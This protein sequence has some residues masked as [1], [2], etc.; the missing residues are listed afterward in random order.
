M[1]VLNLRDTESREQA[2]ALRGMDLWIRRE[3]ATPLPSD[4]YYH[5]DI[6]GLQMETREGDLVGV[7]SDILVTG[8]NDVYVVQRESGETLVPAIKDVVVEIDTTEGR[9]IIDP[10]HGLLD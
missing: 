10:M 2:Q 1:V 8:A 5:D 4:Q 3:D 9:I 6:V 7:V